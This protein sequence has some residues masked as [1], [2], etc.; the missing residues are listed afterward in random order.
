MLPPMRQVRRAWA[1]SRIP[2]LL[3]IAL[4]DRCRA[5]PTIQGL[6][7]RGLQTGATTVI[8]IDGGDLAGGSTVLLP[9]PIEVQ[10]IKEGGTGERI[11]IEVKLAAEVRPGIYPLRLANERGISSA[12]LV[13]VD[14]L[15]QL[16]LGPEVGNLPVALHG[17]LSG[18]Q[19][20]STSFSGVKGQ[21]VVVDVD[22]R[23]LGGALD[24]IVELLDERRVQVAWSQGLGHLAGDARLETTLPTDGK[25]TVELHDALYRGGNPGLFRLAIGDLLTADRTFPM[26]ARLGS[27]GPVELVGTVPTGTTSEV[28]LSQSLGDGFAPLPPLAG[29]IGPAPRVLGSEFPQFI[30][31]PPAKFQ[32]NEAT[33]P[34]VLNGRLSLPR[35]V[36][37]F[38]VLVQSGVSLRYEMIANRVGSPVDGELKIQ[39]GAGNVLAASEDQAGTTDPGLDFAAPAG[40]TAVYIVVSD[41]I[42]RGGPDCVYQIAITPTGRPDYTLTFFEDRQNVPLAG[43]ALVRVRANRAGFNEA[44]ALSF[45]G[46]PSGVRVGN[47]TIPG[48][49]SDALVSLEGFG[50]SPAQRVIQVVGESRDPNFPAKRLALLPPS[51]ATAAQPWLRSGLGIGVTGPGPLGV[52]WDLSDEFL[53]AG[54]SI[55]A[56]VEI[57][58]ASGIEGPVSLSLV[59]SQV[60]PRT[61]DNQREDESRAIRFEGTPVIAADQVAAEPTIL[62]PPGVPLLPYDLAVRAE[63]LVPDRKNVRAVAF[64]PSRRLLAR[65][66]FTLELAGPAAVEAKSGGGAT[67]TLTGKISRQAAVDEPITLSLVGLPPEIP[68]PALELPVG[69]AEFQFPVSFPFGTPAGDLANI[70]LRGSAGADPFRQVVSAEVPITLKVVAG[71]PPVAAA[72]LLKIFEDDPSFPSYLYE[73]DAPNGLDRTDRYS[74][75]VSLRVGRVQRFRTK[76]PNWSYKITEKPGEGQFRYLRYAWKKRGG[77]NILLQLTANGNFGPPRGAPGPAYRYEAGPSPNP[78]QASAVTVDSKLPVEWTV[79]TRD[80]FADFG[81]F[82]LDGLALTTTDGDF[83]LWDHVYLARSIADFKDCP[84][85]AA[86]TPA[87]VA[88]ASP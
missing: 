26:G 75:S 21:R 69:A 76:M 56:R 86:A 77:T 33:A 84:P 27:K 41:L 49:A 28:D 73:G 42:G 85:P 30:E 61:P 2:F 82:A 15:P 80:L 67:G 74:G 68:T 64:T 47:A 72:P 14:S 3:A 40:L 83:A 59:T 66:P 1:K 10:K 31:A 71:D 53:P 81:E 9:I 63:L 88:T 35:Q 87:P 20:V 58:R 48:G 45:P 4:A 36:D 46:L 19:V 70:R 32:V 54:G 52:V 11:E 50:L 43:A 37:R 55:R 79:V 23:R 17:T 39:D 6:F 60:V 34:V 29:L 24:P 44:I 12:I 18:S 7:P 5:A 57:S 25:Y 16:P 65:H 62:V 38:R 22:A 13:A 8:A 51:G 78:F